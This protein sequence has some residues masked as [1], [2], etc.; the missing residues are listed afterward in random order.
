[1]RMLPQLNDTDHCALYFPLLLWHCNYMLQF[2]FWLGRE[3]WGGH[4]HLPCMWCGSETCPWVPQGISTICN[5]P[6]ISGAN[7][8]AVTV[9]FS[10]VAP[11]SLL[12]CCT[13]DVHSFKWWGIGIVCLLALM[14]H[15]L[16]EQAR[17]FFSS[18]AFG[19]AGVSCC[20]DC[21]CSTEKRKNHGHTCDS[22]ADY[23]LY[24]VTPEKCKKKKKAVLYS[25]FQSVVM[26][27][28]YFS[29]E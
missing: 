2:P 11:F 22:T 29:Q 19:T 12:A 3:V 28:D 8:P 7:L 16:E 14:L 9:S 4:V 18:M 26:C 10:F 23:C 15:T 17:I 20:K 5:K 13:S 27:K 25:H 6:D 21:F 1:M 24:L